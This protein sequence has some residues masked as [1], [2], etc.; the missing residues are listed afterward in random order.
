MLWYQTGP[1]LPAASAIR[2]WSNNTTALMDTISE[3][4]LE[5]SLYWQRWPMLPLVIVTWPRPTETV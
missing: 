2:M 4:V 3:P 1:I 5:E